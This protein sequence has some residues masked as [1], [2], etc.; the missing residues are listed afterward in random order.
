M[1]RFEREARAAAKIQNEH[2]VR[3][4]NVGTLEDGAPYMVMEYLHGSDVRAVLRDGGVL[5]VQDAVDYVLQAAE[6]IA[7]A[8]TLGIVHRDLKPSNLFLIERPDGTPCIKVLDFGISK[9]TST[10]ACLDEASMTR[11]GAV[12]GSPLYMSPEQLYSS[13]DADMRTDVWA[14]GAILF[15]MLSGRP[16]FVADSIPDSS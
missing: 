11:T 16:P 13:R 4:I 6:A 12:L 7:E 15:E 8:H 3:V 9:V 14:L 5:P 1:A 2:T 10:A